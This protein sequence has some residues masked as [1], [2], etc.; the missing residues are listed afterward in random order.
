MKFEL[1]PHTPRGRHCS[2]ETRYPT[3]SEILDGASVLG[4]FISAA[5]CVFAACDLSNSNP[6][7]ATALAIFSVKLTFDGL[8]IGR[9]TDF[10]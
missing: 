3:P 7:Y 6:G 4:R 5:G 10:L 8:Y 9:E 1:P 2:G